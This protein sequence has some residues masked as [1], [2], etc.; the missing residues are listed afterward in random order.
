MTSNHAAGFD[1]SSP[2]RTV[3]RDGL[4]RW[5]FQEYG[6]LFGEII[7]PYDL[8]QNYPVSSGEVRDAEG[9][10]GTIVGTPFRGG[11]FIANV[12]DDVIEKVDLNVSSTVKIV[13]KSLQKILTLPCTFLFALGHYSSSFL[14]FSL[15]RNIKR[16]M[17]MT[18]FGFV[19]N[20]LAMSRIIIIL[21]Q[22][23]KTRRLVVP[24]R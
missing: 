2:S 23:C 9:M 21:R 1:V 14:D 20:I 4:R 5:T 10:I 22:N 13:D 8:I 19:G 16:Y 18:F 24:G 12:L 3:G 17:I 7:H 15:C 6:L 11:G